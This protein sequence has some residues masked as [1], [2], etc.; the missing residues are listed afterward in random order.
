ME[1]PT[2]LRDSRPSFSS[3]RPVLFLSVKSEDTRR[4]RASLIVNTNT[5][6]KWRDEKTTVVGLHAGLCAKLNSFLIIAHVSLHELITEF[7]I[8]DKVCT[9]CIALMEKL[10]R[11]F[12]TVVNLLQILETGG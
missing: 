10:D 3:S 2:S 1:S 6:C 12:F 7:K 9:S 4:G 8:T 5:L 11:K